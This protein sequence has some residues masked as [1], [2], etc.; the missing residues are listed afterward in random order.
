MV[1]YIFLKPYP[2]QWFPISNLKLST[3]SLKLKELLTEPSFL[4]HLQKIMQKYF[5]TTGVCKPEM[6]Y[7]VNPLRGLKKKIYQ[8]I[9]NKQYFIIHASRQT[10]KTTLLH[11]LAKMINEEGQYIAVVFSVEKAG[12]ESI[13]VKDANHTYINSLYKKALLQLEKEYLPPS[14]ENIIKYED[15]FY[16][17]LNEWAS[18]Q[19]KEIVLLIDEIDALHDDV[20]ISVLRQLRD[21]FQDRPK[22]FPSSIAL[23][24]LR[25]IREYRE[26]ARSKDGSLGAGSP[27]N[28]KAESF[29]LEN[30]SKDNVFELLEQHTTETQQVFP[31]DVKEKIYNYTSGQPW[32][33]NALAR[34]IVYS[35]YDNDFSRKIT[36]KDVVKAKKNIIQRRD[37]H[38]D[39]LLDK[40]QNPRVKPIVQAIIS[41]DD[42]FYDSYNDDLLYTI[43]L[44]IVKDTEKGIEFANKIY[45]EIIPRTLNLQFQMAIKSKI[46]KDW[47]KTEN[48]KLDM[49]ALLKGFQKFY[50]R[51]SESWIDLYSYKEAGQQL[52]LMAYLQRIINSGGTIDREMAIGSGRTD[53]EISYNNEIFI[54]E[55]KINRYNY[56]KEDGFEQL[57]RYLDKAGQKHGY[58]VLFEPKETKNKTWE[59]RIKWDKIKYEYKNVEKIITIVEM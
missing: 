2:V 45:K 47:Y 57:S 42:I 23:I 8:L 24:G 25:D 52:L 11:H 17:Y 51:H 59:E 54:L 6:H 56:V 49:D 53:I 28:I 16:N 30:F 43:D 33:V 29:R 48:G 18:K 21:G 44:G 26:K 38:L 50:R 14:L 37:T 13:S 9:E 5:N 34:E 35:I 36:V 46:E 15:A 55:L 22:S 40:L 19:K 31:E 20:L 32:L 3:R 1:Q 7:I 39:S 41:G 12:Y 10:G 58:L 4:N 27:F